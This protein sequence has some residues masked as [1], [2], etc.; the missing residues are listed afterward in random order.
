MQEIRSGDVNN[1]T[2]Q[3]QDI[4]IDRFHNFSAVFVK[5][6]AWRAVIL[7]EI[8]HAFSQSFHADAGIVSGH[9]RFLPYQSRFIIH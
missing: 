2:N 4:H 5:L 1:V 6:K 9:D 3:L 7:A 8:V